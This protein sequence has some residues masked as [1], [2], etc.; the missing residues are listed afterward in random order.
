MIKCL[1]CGKE[2]EPKRKWQKFCKTPCRLEFHKMVKV[3]IIP[4]IVQ[5]WDCPICGGM[6]LYNTITQTIL[7]Q[8][9]DCLRV[10]RFN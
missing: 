3:K 9:V 5:V 8:N 2:F 1:N 10:E 7:C 4:C 6:Q